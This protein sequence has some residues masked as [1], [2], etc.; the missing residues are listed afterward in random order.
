MKMQTDKLT[1][2][3]INDRDIEETILYS[4][5]HF[6]EAREDIGKINEDDF[7]NLEYLELFKSLRAYI[8]SSKEF[9]IHTVPDE[10]KKNKTLLSLFGKYNVF[11]YKWKIYLEKLKD[12]SAKRSIQK[13]AYEMTMAVGENRDAG[14][15]KKEI[16]SKIGFVQTGGRQK[17]SKSIMEVVN[18]DFIP[19]IDS[20]NHRGIKIGFSDIDKAIRGLFPGRV[21]LIGGIPTAGKTTFLLNILQNICR[22][23]KKVLFASLEMPYEDVITKMISNLAN[24]DMECI[25]DVDVKDEDIKMALKYVEEI[26]K[27]DLHFMGKENITI[28]DIENE[29]DS[30]GGVDIVL[31]DY[32]QKILPINLSASR[33]EQITQISRDI[34][35]L[36]KN[37]GI[38]VVS[39]ASINRSFS[40]R[41]VKKPALSDFRDS[42]NV[43]YDIDVA[44]LLYREAQFED[45]PDNRKNVTEIIIAKNRQGPGGYSVEM[46][47][48]PNSSKFMLLEKG[49]N[50]RRKDIYE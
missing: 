48:D 14:Q 36:A 41:D 24:R 15:I 13:I 46:F 27:Y 43:E 22:A 25:R 39:V 20:T 17:R 18:D 10:I 8:M 34:T 50:G 1:K 49:I 37:F 4:L 35:G 7:Y 33:Y 42:G 9:D 31:I 12:I 40:K 2:L 29:I 38:P 23:G 45:V 5:I 19:M 30:L 26:T 11:A 47:F 21:Y 3:S 6:P 16:L 44:F 28:I 32:L